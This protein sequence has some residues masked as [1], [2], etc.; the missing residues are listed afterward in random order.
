MVA[1]DADGVPARHFLLAELDQVN[2]QA[3]GGLG[4]IDVLPA[5]DDLLEHVVL[6][7]AAHLVPGDALLLGQGQVH[8]QQYRGRGVD[9]HAGGNFVQGDLVKQQAHVVDRVDGDAYFAHLAHG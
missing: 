8:T 3:H 6:D 7:G 9:G 5:A 4:G 2:G 1:A